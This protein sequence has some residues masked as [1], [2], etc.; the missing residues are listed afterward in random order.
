[1]V[2]NRPWLTMLAHAVLI[3]GAALMVAPVWLAF[4]ASTYPGADFLSGRLPL[5][6]GSEVA[7][8]YRIVLSQGLSNAGAPPIGGMLVNS[9]IVAVLIAVGKIAVSLL[10]AFAIVYFR[11]PFRVAA[12][13]I[14]FVTL[15]LPVEVRILPTYEVVSQL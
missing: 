1:M 10:S 13:W 15:M 9:L 7:T 6:P 4:V 8:N 14:I 2:E 5:W 12:F 11:F 3:V